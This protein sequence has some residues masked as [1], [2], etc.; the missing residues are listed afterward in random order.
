MLTVLLVEDDLDLAR[1]VVEYLELEQIECDHASNG[2]AGLNLLED[3][4]YDVILLDINLPRL[5]GLS[6]CQKIREQGNET[7]VLMLTAMGQLEDKI[8]GFNAGTDDYLVK[9][10]ELKE[11]NARVRALSHRKSKRGN[12]LS[13]GE[14]IMNLGSHSVNRA[15]TELKLSPI[16]W[17]L[18]EALLKHSPDV[19]SKQEL[20][21]AV[22]G[23]EPPDSNSLKVHLHNLRKVI[24]APFEHALIQTIPGH[25][26]T[27]RNDNAV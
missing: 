17:Q 4:R 19:V 15:G 8:E 21:R 7:P 23:S 6:L 9:P 11:L 3:N 2:I 1:T 27:I 13:C 10:F 26:F 5:N 22:W 12:V 14:L 18:L 20:E 16:A 25:G 24:D